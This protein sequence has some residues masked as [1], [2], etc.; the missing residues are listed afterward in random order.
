MTYF[1]LLE[2]ELGGVR[3][4]KKRLV[5]MCENE[6]E[7]ELKDTVDLE[8]EPE[9]EEQIIQGSYMTYRCPKCGKLLKPEFPFRIVDRR[10]GIDIF[11]IP[12]LDRGAF[13]RKKLSYDIGSPVRV[14][15]GFPELIEKLTVLREKL[16]DRAVEAI[17]MYL[18]ERAVS[19]NME[20]EA[21]REL[22]PKIWFDRREDQQL[23][24]KI[25]GLKK[26]SVGI[27]RISMGTYDKILKGLAKSKDRAINLIISP[28]Y[29]SVN[30]LNWE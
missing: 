28:P 3:V 10:K 6:F 12:E 27:T 29:V 25:E 26:D 4:S 7:I 2:S 16:D 21:E 19:E 13:S 22:I 24:F 23:I 15:I 8:K 30:K 20:E 17:K 9:V 5:C 18:L 1:F 14:V 11:F